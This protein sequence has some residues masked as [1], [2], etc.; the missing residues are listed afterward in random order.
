[1]N[2]IWCLENHEKFPMQINSNE[3]IA[4]DLKMKFLNSTDP[5]PI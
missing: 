4:N 3:L 2:K 5:F 1:M